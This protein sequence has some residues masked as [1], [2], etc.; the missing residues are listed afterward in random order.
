[1]KRRIFAA[2]TL[3]LLLGCAGEG[4]SSNLGGEAAAEV[5]AYVVRGRVLELWDGERLAIRHEPIEDFRGVSGDLEPMAEMS[6]RF[7]AA[8]GLGVES[9]AVGDEIRFEL[10]VDWQRRPPHQI[11]SFEPLPEGESLQLSR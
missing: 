10:S 1:M 11:E 6:M 9:L 4:P 7:P 2:L 8:A 5:A 3:L